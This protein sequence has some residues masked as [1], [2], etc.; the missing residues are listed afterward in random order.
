MEKI[1]EKQKLITGYLEYLLCNK[2]SL[3]SESERKQSVQIL[4]PKEA[5]RRGSQLSLVFSLP[6]DNVQK[7]LEKRGVVV[8]KPIVA[9][10]CLSINWI[11]F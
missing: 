8:S 11:V 2:F 5:N 10:D 6:L 9:T 1:V 7:E 3:T 4:T